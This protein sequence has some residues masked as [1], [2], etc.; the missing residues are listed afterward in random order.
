MS[1]HPN[2]RK[3][4]KSPQQVSSSNSSIN[5]SPISDDDDVKVIPLISVE[6]ISDSEGES[7]PPQ[8]EPGPSK[9]NSPAK[10]MGLLCSA[11]QYNKNLL[12]QS[13]LK[14][15]PVTKRL[16]LDTSKTT[17]SIADSP[18]QSK[19]RSPNT[20]PLTKPTIGSPK[21]MVQ[22]VSSTVLDLPSSTPKKRSFQEVSST[23]DI[24]P[25]VQKKILFTSL[26]S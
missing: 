1:S 24:Q 12:T 3:R 7:A 4:L 5:V 21:C 14:F 16:K 17:I 20:N 9:L 25:V 13:K 18:G 22:E 11:G 26:D 8:N 19:L 23:V 6:D 10:K 2:K 15:Q